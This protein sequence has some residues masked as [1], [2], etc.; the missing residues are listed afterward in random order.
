MGNVVKYKEKQKAI[1]LYATTP[2]ITIK[3]AALQLNLHWTTI[4]KW[5]QD[6]NF[7]EAI[8]DRYMMEFGGELPAVL[9]AMIREAKSGNVQAGRLVL[10]HSGKLVKN[11]NVTIDSPFEKFLKTDK[12]E[13]EYT[14]AEIQDIVEDVPEPQDMV[15]PEPNK[16][17]PKAR[18]KTEFKNIKKSIQNEKRKNSRNDMYQLKKRAIAIGVDLLPEGRPSKAT[19]EQWIKNI[20]EAEEKAK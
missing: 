9:T 2:N 17:D 14:D 7:I 4:A 15:L 13:V 20:E 18:E 5:R 3:E 16:E 10:E 12:A 1:E 6:P 8:Y 19:K 11:I